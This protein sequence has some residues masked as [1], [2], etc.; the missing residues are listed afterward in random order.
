MTRRFVCSLFIG[1]LISA[2]DFCSQAQLELSLDHVLYFDFPV[3][4][5]SKAEEKQTEAPGVISVVTRDELIR[6]GGTTLKDILERVPGLARSTVY[7][8]DRSVIAI[9]GAQFKEN[10]VHMLLLINGRPVREGLEGGIISEV[11]ESFPTNIIEK[12]E[13]IKGPGSVLYGSGAFAGVINVITEQPEKD[14]VTVTALAGQEYDAMVKAAVRE[15]DFSML[16]AGKYHRRPDWDL[17]LDFRHLDGTTSTI[18]YDLADKGP[19]VYAEMNYKKLKLMTSYEKWESMNWVPDPAWTDFFSDFYGKIQWE[20]LFADLG[21]SQ[22][23]SDK[24]NMGL[25]ITYTGSMLDAAQFPYVERD[26]YYFTVE[27]T[28]YINPTDRMKIIAGGT[29]NYISGTEFVKGCEVPPMPAYYADDSTQSIWGVYTQMD[30]WLDPEK[31]KLIGGVQV[32][33]VEDIKTDIVPRAGFIFYTCPSVSIKIL[34][35]K[36]F[37]A[38][39]LN[40]VNLNAPGLLMGNKDLRSE[41]VDTFDIAL[42]YNQEAFQCG[43]SFFYSKLKEIIRTDRSQGILVTPMYANMSD[44]TAKGFEVEGKY[45]ITDEFFFQASFLYNTSEDENDVEDVTPVANTGGRIGISYASFDKKVI[46]SLHDIYQG[47]LDSKFETTE[48]PSPGS[49]NLLNFNGRLDMDKFFGWR[50]VTFLLRGDNL[51]DKELWLPDW[52]MGG[53]YSIPVLKGRTL[54][55]GVEVSF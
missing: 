17:A 46:L 53:T 23:I 52:G 38:P 12:I 35:S 16:L 40:E 54:Y 25:N 49:Y 55:A 18:F 50:G 7:F 33:K 41:K 26:S 42:N 11:L 28:N 19:G 2:F 1:I 14:G 9:R 31:M 45:Y 29:Y 32:N 30:Y 3:V 48:N 4:T 21:Y 13:V 10:G 15:G 20:K 51:L 6:F 37:R 27:W 34:Y 36:A 8:T 22:R 24:W 5:A 39:G 44:I 43:A 47:N